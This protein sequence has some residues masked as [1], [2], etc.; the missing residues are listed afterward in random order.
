MK[1]L[2]YILAV[3]A[4]FT[5]CQEDEIPI[6]EDTKKRITSF[7]IQQEGENDAI[8]RLEYDTLGKV[9]ELYYNDSLWIKELEANNE[10]VQYEFKDNYDFSDTIP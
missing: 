1:N 8:Y 4:L 9:S 2:I 7:Q 6:E 5:N 3:L 10:L